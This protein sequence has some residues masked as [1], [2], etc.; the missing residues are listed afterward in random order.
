MNV[1]QR[2]GRVL[3]N[4]CFDGVL[5]ARTDGRELFRVGRPDAKKYRYLFQQLF[6]S[7]DAIKLGARGLKGMILPQ[8]YAQGSAMCAYT[9]TSGFYLGLFATRRSRKKALDFWQEAKDSLSK[10]V[11]LL[12]GAKGKLPDRGPP[13]VKTKA[14]PWKGTPEQLVALDE[15]L[16]RVGRFRWFAAAGRPCAKAHVASDLSDAVHGHWR[17][18][19]PKSHSIWSKASH[20]L[21]RK[22]RRREGDSWIDGVFVRVGEST[23]RSVAR[24]MRDY[25][26][27]M[28]RRHPRYDPAGVYASIA[29]DVPDRV[30]SDVAWAAVE[31]LLGSPA[32]FSELLSWHER[33]RWPCGWR[34]GV[35]PKGR[36]V[37]L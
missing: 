14:R 28:A 18:W 29:I 36:I 9:K 6:G 30:L 11:E 4:G 24:G 26:D 10:V 19:G 8:L 34:G 23:G 1:E 2:I 16:D 37:I 7:E 17:G 33:G 32:F 15:F 31:V 35:P 12:V 25:L 22:A 21:E 27:R 3:A 13:P 5:V 20:A